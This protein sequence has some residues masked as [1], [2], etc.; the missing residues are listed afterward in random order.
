MKDFSIKL[1][2]KPGDLARVAQALARRGVN[3]KALAG[4][5]IDGVALARVLPDDTVAARSAFE[6]ANIRFT[7]SEV[8]L[9]LLENT[10]GVLA[11]VANRLGD[12]GVNLEAIYVTGI[13]DDL[14]E[15]AIAS[16]DPKKAKKILEEF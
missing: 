16:D 7:E 8:H 5:S 15:L 12:A 9:V 11:T 2:N 13:A 14:V 3:I 10:A 1:T 4:L 6:A